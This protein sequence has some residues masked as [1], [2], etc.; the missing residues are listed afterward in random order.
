[1]NIIP[2]ET[3]KQMIEEASDID[4]LLEV[5]K[6][7]KDQ[8]NFYRRT[9][10]KNMSKLNDIWQNLGHTLIDPSTRQI[11]NDFCLST[12]EQYFKQI[13]ATLKN[14][15]DDIEKIQLQLEHLLKRITDRYGEM[16]R[17]NFTQQIIEE[18]QVFYNEI[19]D[20]SLNELETLKEQ[21][22]IKMVVLLEEKQLIEKNHRKMNIEDE[23]R[24]YNLLINKLDLRIRIIDHITEKRSA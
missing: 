14:D 18:D 21:I 15:V 24:S 12:V 16:R 1:M 23:I 10:M 5:D 2:I 19:K 3:L 6:I 17:N 13:P 7:V 9:Y 11:S 22:E 4:Q 8:K 20:Y